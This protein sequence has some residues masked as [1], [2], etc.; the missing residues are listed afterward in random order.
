M[1]MKRNTMWVPYESFSYLRNKMHEERSETGKPLNQERLR[2]TFDNSPMTRDGYHQLMDGS[3][4]GC[5]GNPKHAWEEG[6]WTDWSIEDMKAMLDEAGLTYK[7][8]EQIEC[9]SL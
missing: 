8:G 4:G 7:D 2:K 1:K 9:I 6:R 3:F 5:K